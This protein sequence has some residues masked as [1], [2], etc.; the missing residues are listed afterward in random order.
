MKKLIVLVLMTLAS[1]I[2]LVGTAPTASAVTVCSGSQTG[3]TQYVTYNGTRVAALK[4]FYNGSTGNNCA[5]FEHLGP[6]AGVTRYTSVLLQRCSQTAPGNGCTV[7]AQAFDE[8]Y[9]SSY[10][11][12]VHVY[13]PN[14]CVRA[15]GQID[16]G[17]AIRTVWTP[18]IGC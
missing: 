11:G 4:V 7:N 13:A 9:Y 17:G 8:G 1:M 2:T 16:W 3:A 5:Q 10:A 14:N 12:P 15:R 18:V 6:A